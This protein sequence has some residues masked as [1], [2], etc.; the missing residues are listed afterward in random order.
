[1]AWEEE[2]L[3]NFGSSGIASEHLQLNTKAEF[4]H[5][6]VKNIMACITLFWCTET[7]KVQLCSTLPHVAMY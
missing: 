6:V 1:M 4:N 2:N 5:K 3:H 7:A